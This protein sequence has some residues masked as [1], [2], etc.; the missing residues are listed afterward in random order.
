MFRVH[1]STVSAGRRALKKAGRKNLRSE[2]KLKVPVGKF[3]VWVGLPIWARQG[4]LQ[5]HPGRGQSV[6]SSVSRKR[7]HAFYRKRAFRVDGSTGCAEQP[8]PPGPASLPNFMHQ[9]RRL[10]VLWGPGRP[11]LFPKWAFFT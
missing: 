3:C 11:A 9:S 8:E 2:T 5:G 10:G 7:E 1:G 6:E 4:G